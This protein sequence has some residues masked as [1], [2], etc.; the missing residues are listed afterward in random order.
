MASAGYAAALQD[1]CQLALYGI[2]PGTER[3]AAVLSRLGDPQASIPAIH[4]AGTNGKGST[5][6]YCASLLGQLVG[7][8][9]QA[10]G[11]RLRVGLYT[12]PHLQ[13]V[14]E[15]IQLSDDAADGLRECTEDEFVG[16]LAAVR[17]AAQAAPPVTLTF[18]EVLT[19]AAFVLWREAGVDLAVVETGLGGRLDATR[20]CAAQVTVITSIGL[21]HVELLGPTLADIAREKAGIFRPGVPA[22]AA[23]SPP[24]AR[25]VLIAEA[26]R[27][28]APL[29]L[30]APEPIARAAKPSSTPTRVTSPQPS[31]DSTTAAPQP[32]P[33]SPTGTARLLSADS[34]TAAPQ[35]LADSPIGTSRLPSADWTTDKP[36]PSAV[37]PTAAP[38]QPSVGP[39]AGRRPESAAELATILPL[40]GE[41]AAAVPLSGEHQLRNAALAVI[42][43]QLFLRPGSG[44]QLVP[45]GELA[46]LHKLAL[47]RGLV[48]AGLAATRWPGRLERL[49]PPADP[50]SEPPPI[51]LP[52]GV[53]VW[54]DAAH[55]PEGVQALEHWLAAEL[56]ERPLTILFG[57]VAGKQVAQMAAP[58]RR[59]RQVVLTRP[60]SPRG[61]AAADLAAQLAPELTGVAA[62]SVQVAQDWLPALHAA[63]S[64]TA[65]GGL[66]LVYGSIFLIAAV[67]GFFLRE[68]VDELQVQDPGRPPASPL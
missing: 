37:S 3:L 54:L 8:L 5:A 61:L 58:L 63:V 48:R 23:C 28:G 59:A 66:L 4:I 26:Q 49:W 31:A 64:Q 36:R 57:A 50:A 16:A 25:A 30:Y 33:D 67:R 42:A 15:R 65:P 29:R 2:Q 9:R 52:P 43:V 40:D 44:R 32:S 51:T 60:P 46:R 19:A 35:P 68:Q 17:E 24:D 38:P 6:A 45:G 41:L 34:T 21:D 18:F 39:M 56:D 14:R 53:A 62:A 47:D 20:L 1:L 11:P 27:I 12:S 55:N 22:L 10:G 7:A 13:R